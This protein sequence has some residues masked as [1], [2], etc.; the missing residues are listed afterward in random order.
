VKKGDRVV[1]FDSSSFAS[2]LGDKRLAVM[3]AGGELAS[4]RAR[5]AAALADKEMELR[6]KQAELAKARVEV[7]VPQDLYSR[8]QFQEKQLTLDRQQDALA[9]AQEELATERRASGLERTVKSLALQR[10]ERELRELKDR[11]NDLVLRAPRDGMVQ[12][13]INRR[14]GRKFLEG[15]EAYPGWAV[16]SLPQLEEMEVRARLHDVDDGT[17]REGMPVECVLDAYPDQI[18]K[19]RVQMVSALARADGR[20]GTRR[21]FDVR[22]ALDKS[23][24]ERMRPGMSV[25]IEVIRRRAQDVLLVPRVAL[26]SSGGKTLV[27]LGQGADAPVQAVTIDWCTE[28]ACV[29]RGGL[30]EGTAVHLK[31]PPRARGPS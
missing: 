5:A 22:V 9:K 10:A 29:V 23:A 27:R 21:F 14:E 13:E 6:R 30:R 2:A 3:R 11:L 4:E 1:E 7:A 16:A 18:W 31:A 12:V 25:R 19:G 8:R 15:D 26:Q 20:D 17:I 24:P 28:L